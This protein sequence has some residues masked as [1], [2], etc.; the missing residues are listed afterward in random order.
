MKNIILFILIVFVLVTTTSAETIRLKSG[1]Y[2]TG[3]VIQDKDDKDGFW[4]EKL[5]GG[6]VY[7][8]WSQ[9]DEVERDRLKNTSQDTATGQENKGQLIDGIRIITSYRTVEG[10]LVSEK[11]D[12]MNIKTSRGIEIVPINA[13]IKKELAKLRPEDVYSPKE[14]VERMAATC[15]AN[16]SECLI[17]VAEYARSLKLYDE[18]KNYITKAK[19]LLTANNP[20][21]E[22]LQKK[23]M[24]LDAT[25]ILDEINRLKE[26]ADYEKAIDMA[27][28]LLAEYPDTAIAKANTDLIKRLQAEA[29]EFQ[30]NKDKIMAKKVPEE[31]YKLLESLLGKAAGEK[32]MSSAGKYV[33]GS[34]EKELLASLM[35]KFNLPREDIEKYW[36]MRDNTKRLSASYGTGSWIV[37]GGS[38][39]MDYGGGQ[40]MGKKLQTQNEWWGE[41]PNI[42]KKKWLEAYYAETSQY[43]KK[44]S[45]KKDNCT[46]CSGKGTVKATRNNQEVDVTCPRCHGVKVTITITYY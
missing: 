4:L 9:L 15:K 24:E 23:I 28:K 18:A 2:I 27:D 39:G 42:I 33:E 44:V 36:D 14:L 12:V 17:K 1:K 41:T 7:I 25:I 40:T 26:N 37:L 45:E 3:K 29:D 20:D 8:R 19:A 22:K 30:K 31:W 10:I 46:N 16:D 21:S 35:K 43:V 34:L 32:Q 5:D 6:T 13:I 38:Q 11:D